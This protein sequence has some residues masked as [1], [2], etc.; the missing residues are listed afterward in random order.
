MKSVQS[1]FSENGTQMKRIQ[2]IDAETTFTPRSVRAK[3]FSP[4][5]TPPSVQNPSNRFNPCSDK[6]E[7]TQK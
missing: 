5:Y 7:R 4:L 1:M 6:E 3:H 2:R